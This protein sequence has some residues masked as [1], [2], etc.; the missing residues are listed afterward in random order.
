M[1]HQVQRWCAF[2]IATVAGLVAVLPFSSA[3]T[4]G[5]ES[6]PPL[7]VGNVA[8]D[9]APSVDLFSPDG[10]GECVDL[11][12]I[13]TDVGTRFGDN[14]THGYVELQINQSL[15]LV[16]GAAVGADV[17]AVEAV[18]TLLDGPAAGTTFRRP[19]VKPPDV[20]WYGE[21]TL[22]ADGIGQS[23][24]MN[25]K[26]CFKRGTPPPVSDITFADGGVLHISAPV[27]FPVETVVTG[28]LTLV[29]SGAAQLFNNVESFSIAINDGNPIT[30][31]VSGL[32]NSPDVRWAFAV[33]NETA[34]PL[35]S[36]PAVDLV[37]VVDTGDNSNTVTLSIISPS[38]LNRPT[39]QFGTVP[40]VLNEHFN[41]YQDVFIRLNKVP[42][43]LVNPSSLGLTGGG[44]ANDR[45]PIDYLVLDPLWEWDVQGNL[46]FAVNAC[47]PL[48][49][50]VIVNNN[51]DVPLLFDDELG[52]LFTGHVAG[53]VPSGR[54]LQMTLAESVIA[55]YNGHVPDDFQVPANATQADIDE[56][57][58]RTGAKPPNLR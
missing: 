37:D 11:G 50:P 33:A 25:I 41:P 40:V 43:A 28:N 29:P 44:G 17:E 31:P 30:G 34:H 10:D 53:T 20:T 47:N 9:S 27:P 7:T 55:F 13:S 12:V 8:A 6:T 19:M 16:L 21:P 1:A 36:A 14:F 15:V 22:V 2:T 38:H 58:L 45:D 46:H 26:F 48:Q 57:V 51:I 24:K 52:G 39:L 32:F 5:G 4:E 18:I 54:C 3:L 56:I 42:D 35:L 49:E 23:T